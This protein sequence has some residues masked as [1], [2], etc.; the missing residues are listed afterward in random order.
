ML[1]SVIYFLINYE[2]HLIIIFPLCL[3]IIDNL[4]EIPNFN[5]LFHFF[6]FDFI[7][8]LYRYLY[9]DANSF[10]VYL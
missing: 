10:I 4:S 5:Y 3:K 7:A 8:H 9:S 6:Y 1:I 2:F